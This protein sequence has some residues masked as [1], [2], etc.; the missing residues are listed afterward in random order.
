MQ[1]LGHSDVQ[2]LQLLT[3]HFRRHR[4][5]RSPAKIQNEHYLLSSTKALHE[6]PL[7]HL[8]LNGCL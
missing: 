1:M 3:V 6:V 8:E 4:C 7:M 2:T 5:I